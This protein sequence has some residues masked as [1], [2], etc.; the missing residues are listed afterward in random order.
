MRYIHLNNYK[1]FLI[2]LVNQNLN[3]ISILQAKRINNIEIV[4]K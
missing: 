1:R 3:T 2:K 4:Y